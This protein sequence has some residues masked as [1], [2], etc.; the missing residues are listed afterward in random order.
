MI[1]AILAIALST[2]EPLPIVD[3]CEINRTGNSLRQVIIYRWQSSPSGRDHY[4]SQWWSISSEPLIERRG[5]VWMVQ[6]E[7][8]QFL[9]KRVW[10]TETLADPEVQDR[11]RLR[12]DDR[13]PYEILCR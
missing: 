2:R 3:V 6:S 12:E 10:R 4:V 8:R 13:T 7:G 1:A 9:A 11:R 5:G